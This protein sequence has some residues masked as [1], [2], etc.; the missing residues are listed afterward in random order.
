MSNKMNNSIY[1]E[2]N[3]CEHEFFEPYKMISNEF[4]Y[5]EIQKTKNFVVIKYKDSI[6]RGQV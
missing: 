4:D 2:E 3:V 5:S 1:E 6:Y